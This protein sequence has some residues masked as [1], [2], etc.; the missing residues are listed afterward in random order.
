VWLNQLPRFF[1]PPQ[2]GCSIPA[3]ENNAP[4]TRQEGDGLHYRPTHNTRSF[5]VFCGAM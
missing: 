2:I 5:S 1:E 3:I 4:G